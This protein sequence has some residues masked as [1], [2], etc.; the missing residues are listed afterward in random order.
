[1]METEGTRLKLEQD[2]FILD[3]AF[4]IDGG[5]QTRPTG[6]ARHLAAWQAFVPHEDQ[7][8]QETLDREVW[9]QMFSPSLATVFSSPLC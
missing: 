4:T 5:T 7:A 3:P 8:K 1:M 6:Y 2:M 9:D